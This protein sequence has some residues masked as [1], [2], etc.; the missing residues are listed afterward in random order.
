MLNL[1]VRI[2]SPPYM[3]L[4]KEAG[5]SNE[6]CQPFDSYASR[7]ISK[8]ALRLSAHLPGGFTISISPA[9]TTAVIIVAVT[10]PIM[11][12]ENM[13]RMYQRKARL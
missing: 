11:P 10:K 8:L 12:V 4:H 9:A 3:N 1:H 6:T 5:R 2:D 13:F 7:F